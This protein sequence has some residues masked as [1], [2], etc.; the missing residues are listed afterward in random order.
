MHIRSGPEEEREAHHAA[1]GAR[2]LRPSRPRSESSPAAT[3][4]SSKIGDTEIGRLVLRTRAAV[5]PRTS[6]PRRDRSCEAPHFQ[7]HVGGQ[8]RASRWTTAPSSSRSP[9]TSRRCRAAT[10]HGSIGEEPVV[11][12][13]LVRREQLRQGGMRCSGSRTRSRRRSSP[14]IC[15]PSSSRARTA[16]TSGSTRS[17]GSATSG[18]HELLGY[19]SPASSTTRRNSSNGSVHE[20][21]QGS[22]M[23]RIGTGSRRSSIPGDGPPH[24][25]RGRTARTAQVETDMIPLT[26]GGHTFAYHFVRVVRC[27]PCSG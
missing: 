27:R 8:A 13:G 23:D 26:Y 9:A 3:P 11:V 5:G 24:E 4:T 1:D 16:S 12:I 15:G 6:R 2:E 18:S 25:G 7:Y 10:M 20:D 17:T 21:D 22:F 19:G 14:S